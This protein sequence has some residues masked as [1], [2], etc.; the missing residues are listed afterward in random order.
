AV[1]ALV[2]R[3][4][5]DGGWGYHEDVPTDA[6]STAWALL[7]LALAGDR[8]DAS[9]RAALCLVGH[10]RPKSGGLATYRDPREI[11]RFMG[12]GRWMRFGGWCSP[13]LEPTAT[14]GQAFAALSGIESADAVAAWHYVRSRQRPD[15][16]WPSYWWTSP[17]FA[18][19]QA[20]E[21]AVL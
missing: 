15:G 8:R 7:L 3:Q 4:N 20:V 9:R 11:R 17:H 6:D 14:A 2:A 10:R 13:H 5:A 16:S 12:V 1:E 18:T 21:L 19:Q